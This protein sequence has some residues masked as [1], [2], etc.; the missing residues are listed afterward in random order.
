M[1]E[2]LRLSKT[3]FVQRTRER[4]GQIT[5]AYMQK[6]RD[7]DASVKSGAEPP[8]SANEAFA[9]FVMDWLQTLIDVVYDD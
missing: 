3:E 4:S 6:W 7:W 5:E 2:E 9:Q 8:G 1:T